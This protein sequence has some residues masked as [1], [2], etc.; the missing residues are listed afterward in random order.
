MPQNATCCSP[1]SH[2]TVTGQSAY[3]VQW[4]C[5][6]ALH[7]S[8]QPPVLLLSS[9]AFCKGLDRMQ[10]VS[11]AAP[12]SKNHFQQRILPFLLCLLSPVCFD[13]VLLP[14]SPRFCLQHNSLAVNHAAYAVT[15]EWYAVAKPGTVCIGCLMQ[16]D[17]NFSITVQ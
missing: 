4:K 10:L 1:S 14:P 8:S 15:P 7:K 13:V 2:R 5:A 9:Q 3:S 17:T 6:A 12:A 11:P 16:Y